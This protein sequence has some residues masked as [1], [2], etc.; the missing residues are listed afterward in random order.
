MV[1]LLRFHREQCPF[2]APEHLREVESVGVRWHGLEL[3]RHARPDLIRVSV[4]A[5]RQEIGVEVYLFVAHLGVFEPPPAP[6]FIPC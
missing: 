1:V 4:G 2:A 5:T 6:P 3:A